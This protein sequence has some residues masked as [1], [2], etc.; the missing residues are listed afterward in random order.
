LTRRARRFSQI[1]GNKQINKSIKSQNAALD[2]AISPLLN[3][4]NKGVNRKLKTG[5]KI[6]MQITSIKV[7]R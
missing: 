7:L 5:G 3:K 4:E 1:P 2:Q 6:V